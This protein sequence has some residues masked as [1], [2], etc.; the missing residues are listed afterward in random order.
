MALSSS[1]RNCGASKDMANWGDNFCPAC[2]TVAK[3]AEQHFAAE[4]PNAAESD[5]LYAGRT[6]MG[7]RSMRPGSSYVDPRTFSAARRASGAVDN[8]LAGDRGNPTT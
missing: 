8:R 2:T 5:I 1:C 6:A 4:N 7:Q 3:E